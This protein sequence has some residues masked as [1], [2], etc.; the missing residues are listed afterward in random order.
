MKRKIALIFG[1]RSL[2][3]DISVITAMQALAVLRETDF[4]VTPVYIAADGGFY[5]DG[6]D[7]VSAFTP[8]THR[9][10]SGWCSRTE[11]FLSSGKGS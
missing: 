6:V 1:G 7:E 3:S 9:G 2:E 11:C 8:S 10:T 5:A 4:D